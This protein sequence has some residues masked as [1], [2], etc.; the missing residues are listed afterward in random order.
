M[1]DRAVSVLE[2]YEF[3]V[4][5]TWKGRGAILCETSQGLKILKE[6]AG[7]KDKLVVQDFLLQSL[8]SKGYER[9]EQIVKNRE[10]SLYSMEN[11]QSAYFVKDY[12]EGRECNVKDE[13]ECLTAMNKLARLHQLSS[14]QECPDFQNIT[15]FSLQKEYEKHNRELKKVNHYIKQKSQKTDFEIFLMK[16]YDLFYR[17]AQTVETELKKEDWTDFEERIATQKILCHGDFQHHNIL[18]SGADP[19]VIN[20]EKIILDSR[21]RDIYLFMRKVLEKNGWSVVLGRKIL[22]VYE[23]ESMLTREEKRQLYYR[24]TYPEKFWKIV[25]FYFNSGKAFISARNTEKLEKL[26]KNRDDMQNFI[27]FLESM[28]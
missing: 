10:G 1:D 13:A 28:L 8:R 16:Y 23:E 3:K 4:L 20:F 6:Y 14:V 21:V 2:Q 5:R 18:F 9:T 22:E 12:F 19:A 27:T 7:I 24:F 11:E 17:Q 25:N 15:P 26:L